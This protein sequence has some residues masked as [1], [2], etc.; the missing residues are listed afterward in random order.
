MDVKDYFK[1]IISYGIHNEPKNLYSDV[2]LAELCDYI[3]SKGYSEN[4]NVGDKIGYLV[5]MDKKANRGYLDG[6]V[7]WISFGSKYVQGNYAWSMSLKK[8]LIKFKDKLSFNPY[9]DCIDFIKEWCYI[10]DISKKDVILDIIDDDIW[11]KVNY[12][13]DI[14]DL[15]KYLLNRLPYDII[16]D[17]ENTRKGI[18]YIIGLK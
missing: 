4:T 5:F 8:F 3:E 6:N 17:S 12:D 2:N 18:V 16:I 10:N 13:I 11:F 9:N 1:E 15:Q 7:I 14:S